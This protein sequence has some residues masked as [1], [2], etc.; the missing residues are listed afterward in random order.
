M[1]ARLHVFGPPTVARD[2]GPLA[3]PSERRSQLLA[4]LTLKRVWVGRAERAR[5]IALARPGEP[6]ARVCQQG[7][8]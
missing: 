1:P 5:P 3:L 4:F 7:D 8:P 2:A 6:Y